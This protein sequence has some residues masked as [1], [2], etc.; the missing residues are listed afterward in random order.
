MT[1]PNLGGDSFSAGPSVET[2][3]PRPSRAARAAIATLI[4]LVLPGMGQLYVQRVLRGVVIALLDVAI[5]ALATEMRLFMT[6][7]G[8]IAAISLGIL[9]RLWVAADSFYVAWRFD[10][11]IAPRRNPREMIPAIMIVFLLVGYPVPSYFGKRLLGSFRAYRVPSRSMCPTICV[12]DRIVVATDAYRGRTPQRGDLIAFHFHEGETVYLK[13]VIGTQGDR[14]IFGPETPISVNGNKLQLPHACGGQRNE[15]SD[16]VK[17]IPPGSLTVPPASFFVIGDNL[18][19][20]YD[21]RIDD[22]G[23]VTPSQL[24]GRPAFIYWSPDRSRIGC[25]LR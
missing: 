16:L 25:K 13:R 3:K 4:S 17:G 8:M 21:S 24:V 18:G 15:Q 14:V 23:F 6:F 20:S 19:D 7:R 10:R 22:F 11:R 1:E 12:G 2:A 5:N 9:W